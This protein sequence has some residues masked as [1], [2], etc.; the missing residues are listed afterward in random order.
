MDR[1]SMEDKARVMV[2]TVLMEEPVMRFMEQMKHFDEELFL[3]SVNVAFITA[4]ICIK[5]DIELAKA[6]NIVMGALLHDIGKIKLSKK[7]LNKK[8]R[9]TEEE[10][11]QVKEHV[12]YGYIMLKH[13]DSVFPLEVYDI[14]LHHHER[15]NGDGYP[16][17]WKPSQINVPLQIVM[18]V[19][20]YDALTAN[21]CY[22][23]IYKKEE[24][25]QMLQQDNGYNPQILVQL[26][27]CE[28][29]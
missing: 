17:G 19:D 12:K 1:K 21:R 25:A 7:I 6:R 4:Q 28:G 18:C 14:V 29:I 20:A 3:H 11:Q 24:A 23:R 8:E 16:E 10:F 5:W 9:L 26:F 15:M 22:G 27:T 13:S 2:D